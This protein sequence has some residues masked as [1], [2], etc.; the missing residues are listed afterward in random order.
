MYLWSLEDDRGCEGGLGGGKG[1]GGRDV[2]RGPDHWRA[3][4]ERRRGGRGRGEGVGGF[5]RGRR[6]GACPWDKMLD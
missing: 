3:L 5:W 2:G 1:R 6:A 4:G